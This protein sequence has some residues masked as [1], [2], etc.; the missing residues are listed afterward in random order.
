MRTLTGKGGREFYARNVNVRAQ[1]DKIHYAKRGWRFRACMWIS[2]PKGYS[3]ASYKVQQSVG[4]G[5]GTNPRT[6]MAHAAKSFASRLA[7]GGQKGVMSTG[8]RGVFAGYR[9]GRR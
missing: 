9:R 3:R 1:V 8:R 5:T 4:C 6:A 7:G 2:G